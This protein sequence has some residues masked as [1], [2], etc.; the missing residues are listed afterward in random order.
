MVLSRRS[1]LQAAVLTA[2][3]GPLVELGAR[4]ASGT[5]F[6][7]VEAIVQRTGQSALWLLVASL[8]CTPAYTVLG[9]RW[10]IPLRRTLGLVAFAYASLHVLA[11]VGLDFGFD[12]RLIATDGLAERPYIVVGFAAYVLLAALAL[13]STRA[14]MRR[15]G[16][17]WKR[18]HRAVY[19]AAALVFVHNTWAVKPGLYET[20]PVGLAI[21]LLLLAR[22]PPI[23]RTAAGLRRRATVGPASPARP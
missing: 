2:A 1:A 13:T 21:G 22:V 14:S 15:L 7:P 9:A 23:R 19:A 8:S 18:L 12:A 6:E 11:V 10:A 20:W 16:K 17:R 4:L 5:V 3:A